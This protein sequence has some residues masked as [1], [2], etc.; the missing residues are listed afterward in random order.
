MY[1]AP[2]LAR[3]VQ[4]LGAPSTV[5]EAYYRYVE[6]RSTGSNDGRLFAVHGII[7]TRTVLVRR[8]WALI[9]RRTRLGSSVGRAED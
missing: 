6:Q 3:N 1:P 4:M 2:R 8:R 7:D 5:A 9:D